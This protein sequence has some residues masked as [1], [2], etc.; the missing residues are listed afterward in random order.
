ML[1]YVQ[2]TETYAHTDK[3]NITAQQE[4]LKIFNDII[5]QFPFTDLKSNQQRAEQEQ[6]V[7]NY[8]FLFTGYDLAG[9]VD[10]NL[11][12]D[13]QVESRVARF[14]QI[15]NLILFKKYPDDVSLYLTIKYMRNLLDSVKLL[16]N[17]SIH[18]IS[19][20]AY[21]DDIIDLL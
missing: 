10:N 6:F 20:P 5:K 11:K 8:F 18:T 17:Y 2:R 12:Q 15:M 14:E 3:I 7:K 4:I 1:V 9:K 13:K 16:S 21:E 19:D